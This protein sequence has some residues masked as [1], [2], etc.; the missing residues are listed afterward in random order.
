MRRVSIKC[1]VHQI[2]LWGYE[3]HINILVQ[4]SESMRS[5][6]RHKPRWGHNIKMDHNEMKSVVK[7]ILQLSHDRDQW[8][9]LCE[10]SNDSLGSLQVRKFLDG[11]N[12][13]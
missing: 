1:A 5:Y 8:Q 12:D 10:C 11:L 9:A 6:G 13:Y 3:K 2:I 4:K 7:D